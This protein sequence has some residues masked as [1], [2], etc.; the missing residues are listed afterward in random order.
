[1][2]YWD[3]ELMY[4]K[5]LATK[6]KRDEIIQF[7][8]SYPCKVCWEHKN[9]SDF[10]KH[11]MENS[12]MGK[13]QFL[14]ECKECKR[15]RM[16]VHRQGARSTIEWA[17]WLVLKQLQQWAKKRSLDFF[18]S[19][20]DLMAQWNAQGWRCYYTGYQMEYELS[21]FKQWSQMEKSKLTVSC[22]RLDSSVGYQRDNIV[23]CCAVVNRMKWNLSCDEFILLCK[24]IFNFAQ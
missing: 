18:I 24:D 13:Y 1:M 4:E 11:Y 8:E 15:N 3:Q 20:D 2:N 9:P 19:T 16:I 12:Y 17:L 7:W 21:Y 6:Q 10:V 23:L 22:D 14:H 5:A